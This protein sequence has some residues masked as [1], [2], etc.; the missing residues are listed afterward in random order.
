MYLFTAEIAESAE[1]TKND[2]P[3]SLCSLRAQR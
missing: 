1:T 3:D 2:S